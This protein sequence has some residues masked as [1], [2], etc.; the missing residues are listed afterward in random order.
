M[1]DN[2]DEAMLRMWAVVPAAEKT[3]ALVQTET[4]IDVSEILMPSY[5]VLHVQPAF[6][7]CNAYLD[8]LLY[9]NTSYSRTGF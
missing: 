3:N 9:H 7:H 4:T 8:Q 5:F 6:Y 1:Q 2:I